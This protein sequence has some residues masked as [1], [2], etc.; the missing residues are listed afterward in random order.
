MVLVLDHTK[1][2]RALALRRRI[3]AMRIPCAVSAV[4]S[5][6]ELLPVFCIV[7]FVDMV[8]EIYR[9][10][11]EKYKTY[12]L[13]DKWVN[14]ATGMIRC[15][16]EKELL[17]MVLQT[18]RDSTGLTSRHYREQG[19]VLP[20]GFFA[21]SNRLFYRRTPL[22]MSETDYNIILLL[23]LTRGQYY[24][25]RRIIAYCFRDT[26]KGKA[27][28]SAASAIY[29]INKRMTDNFGVKLISYDRINGG[30]TFNL[31]IVRQI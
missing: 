16:N 2:Q 19:V 20:M 15:Q 12:V 10:P 13:T 27:N 3:L 30:Y 4:W 7:T 25:A 28:Y 1:S 31:Q 23:L 6:S 18:V 22:D 8:D 17:R 5:C 9:A 14:S 21:V 11:L 26:Y 29:R 24:T